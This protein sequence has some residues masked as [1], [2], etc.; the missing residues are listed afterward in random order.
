MIFKPIHK[1]LIIK[2]TGITQPIVRVHEG[3][4]FLVDL[5][6]KIKMNPVTKAQA[7]YVSEL[8]NEGLTGSVNLATSH[9]AFHI[10]DKV[11]LLMM[12]VYSCKEFDIQ[13]VF[14][15][16][17][18]TMGISNIEYLVIDRETG[19]ISDV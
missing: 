13:V 2:A 9:V 14:D 7:V 10:W 17:E 5:V 19:D 16:I 12:D 1:H 4:K 6:H 18:D 3:K 15:H 11:G 8:G